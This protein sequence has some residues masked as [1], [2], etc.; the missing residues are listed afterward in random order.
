MVR[1]DWSQISEEETEFV[2]DLI[3]ASIFDVVRPNEVERYVKEG[4]FTKMHD[5]HKVYEKAE[6]YLLHRRNERCFVKRADG[7]F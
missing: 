2:K 6:K 1:L 5:I 3:R 7:T 4:F